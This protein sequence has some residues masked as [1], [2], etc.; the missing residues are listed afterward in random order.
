MLSVLNFRQFS[1]HSGYWL[2]AFLLLIFVY[3]FIG[4]LNQAMTYSAIGIP[5]IMGMTYI[6]IY[7]AVPNYLFKAKKILFVLITVA[8]FLI[9]LNIQIII[10]MIQRMLIVDFTGGIQIDIGAVPEDIVFLILSTFM[11]SLPAIF[12]ESLRRWEIDRSQI[13]I[14]KK[15]KTKIKEYYENKPELL[16]VRSDKKTYRLPVNDIRY[17]ESYGDYSHIHLA[18][19]KVISRITLKELEELLPEFI[20]VHRSYI[21]NSNHCEAFN[22]DEVIINGVPIPI[23]R[24]YKDNVSQLTK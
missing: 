22:S 1:I 19:Q 23:G 16:T 24:T 9:V 17:I 12:Y 8:L 13:N 4:S 6:I 20:R 7:W 11:I 21:I 3:S 14:L 10:V 5:L 18:D 15:E 2:S